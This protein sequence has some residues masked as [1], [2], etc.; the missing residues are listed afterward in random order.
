ML[1][2]RKI[3]KGSNMSNK[4]DV[5]VGNREGLCS[6]LLLPECSKHF[7]ASE[8]DGM[9]VLTLPVESQT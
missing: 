5:W 2:W 4:W 3:Q 1:L 8:K 9:A 6:A 7:W